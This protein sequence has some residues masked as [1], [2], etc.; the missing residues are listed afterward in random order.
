[1]TGES[2]PLP[3]PPNA[4]VEVIMLQMLDANR[5]AV[6]GLAEDPSKPSHYVSEYLISVGKEVIPVNPNHTQVLGRQCY[7][8]LADVPGS[9]DLVNVFRRPE[10]CSDVVRDAIAVGARGV[11]LQSGIVS[12]EAKK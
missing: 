4:E 1:M 12:A 11:W 8:S 7:P 10:F 5:I 6:V 2:C 3:T 9:I